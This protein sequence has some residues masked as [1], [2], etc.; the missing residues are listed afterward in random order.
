MVLAALPKRLSE[1]A[2]AR[3]IG[4]TIS[5]LRQSFMIARNAPIYS[6][7]HTFRLDLSANMLK[8]NPST[9]PEEIALRCG[10]GHYGVFRRNYRRRFGYEP[11]NC[12]S[13]MSPAARTSSRR[14]PS[15][16]GP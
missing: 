1:K 12:S 14:K 3:S 13:T 11:E 4:I 15:G 2:M 7:L 16:D 6:A 9:H 10:F 5:D 8:E